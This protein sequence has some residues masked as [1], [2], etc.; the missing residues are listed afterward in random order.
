MIKKVLKKKKKKKVLKKNTPKEVPGFE[1]YTGKNQ[2]NLSN[3]DEPWVS[4]TLKDEQWFIRLEPH[5]AYF[6]VVGKE[7]RV[8]GYSKTAQDGFWDMRAA[9][10]LLKLSKARCEEDLTKAFK[11]NLSACLSMAFSAT[12]GKALVERKSNN[13]YNVVIVQD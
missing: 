4:G 13:S 9:V 10:E 5:G 8:T 2:I 7:L 12:K 3:K 11:E 6:W 1:Q